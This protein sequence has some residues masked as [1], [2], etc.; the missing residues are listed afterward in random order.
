M[1]ENVA[2]IK[3]RFKMLIKTLAVICLTSCLRP[4]TVSAV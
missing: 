2:E 4:N 1:S 3:K